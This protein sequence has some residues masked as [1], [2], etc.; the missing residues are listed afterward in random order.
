[1][2]LPPNVYWFAEQ[3]VGVAEIAEIEQLQEA[4]AV[5]FCVNVH[6][7]FALNDAATVHAAPFAVKPANVYA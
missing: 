7:A 5:K 6:A 2:I 3:A 4:G 1:M